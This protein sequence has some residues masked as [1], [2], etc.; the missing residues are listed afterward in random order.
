MQIRN[1]TSVFS[2]IFETRS[3]RPAVRKNMLVFTGRRIVRFA[4]VL[5]ITFTGFSFGFTKWGPK[6]IAVADAKETQK[7]SL[8]LNGEESKICE[9][10]RMVKWKT[11]D[12]D[13]TDWLLS[14]VGSF[15]QDEVALDVAE[16]LALR[17]DPRVFNA[18]SDIHGW[19]E[20]ARPKGTIR[21]EARTHIAKVMVI[22]YAIYPPAREEVATYLVTSIPLAKGLNK[23]NDFSYWQGFSSAAFIGNQTLRELIERVQYLRGANSDGTEIHLVRYAQPLIEELLPGFDLTIRHGLDLYQSFQARRKRNY[24]GS[25]KNRQEVTDKDIANAENAILT[26]SPKGMNLEKA[27]AILLERSQFTREKR[28]HARLL[29]L[30]DKEN[31]SIKG[32]WAIISAFGSD[33][34]I[35]EDV[36]KRL[37]EIIDHGDEALV[38]ATARALRWKKDVPIEPLIKRRTAT[39]KEGIKF[40]LENVLASNPDPRV[41]PV[42][43]EALIEMKTEGN[44]IRFQHRID[45]LKLWYVLL[46]NDRDDILTETSKYLT[47]ERCRGLIAW[48]RDTTSFKFYIAPIYIGSGWL[49]K[50][51]LNI[52]DTEIAGKMLPQQIRETLS[53]L[54]KN[55]RLAHLDYSELAE[56]LRFSP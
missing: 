15:I 45:N 50:N 43:A 14:F 16:A 13:T 19:F 24:R 47:P 3:R 25:Y 9:K 32:K 53:A 52:N 29:E 39:R 54:S 17:A 7:V 37:L 42:L 48:F 5:I 8:N 46:G 2:Y 20:W 11:D 44:I 6:G 26:P 55:G 4:I 40:E 21:S 49:S 10:I 56:A 34:E 23:G 51:T 1:K 27:I 31:T 12:P 30:L 22:H 35:P 18:V 33:S 41:A 36:Q 38:I 28:Y